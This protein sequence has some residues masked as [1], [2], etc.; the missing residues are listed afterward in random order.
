MSAA[1]HVSVLKCLASHPLVCF[2]TV[3]RSFAVSFHRVVFCFHCLER[4]CLFQHVSTQLL[5]MELECILDV[6]EK[7]QQRIRTEGRCE[8]SSQNIRLKGMSSET[9]AREGRAYKC[10]T[11]GV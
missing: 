5:A 8:K 7:Q 10:M 11:V 6:N 1:V 9:E 3:N 4:M 2:H